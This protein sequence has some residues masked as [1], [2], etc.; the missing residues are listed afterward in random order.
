MGGVRRRRVGRRIEW[1]T[2]RTAQFFTRGL[3]YLIM[4]CWPDFWVYQCDREGMGTKVDV[5]YAMEYWDRT[6]LHEFYCVF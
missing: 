1:L 3:E 4:W 2:G 5:W 6:S